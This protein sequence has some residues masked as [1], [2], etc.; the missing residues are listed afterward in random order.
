[1]VKF[2]TFILIVVLTSCTP[3]KRLQRLLEKHPEL[4]VNDTI[5]IRDTIII[6]SYRTDTTTLLVHHTTTE[7]INNERVRLVYRYDTLTNEIHHEVE[8]KEV[9][10]VYERAIPIERIVNTNDVWSYVWLVLVAL[11]VVFV[12]DRF[13]R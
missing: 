1:M 13:I 7:V 6:P 8:C 4:T 10:T 11:G 2:L 5:F 9:A 3:Q 12:W